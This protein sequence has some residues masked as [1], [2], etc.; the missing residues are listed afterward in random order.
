[1]KER[2]TTP[3][4]GFTLIE[5]IIVVIV[6]AVLAAISIPMYNNFQERAKH[7]AVSESV[8]TVHTAVVQNMTQNNATAED[9]GRL[10]T[11]QSNE[12]IYIYATRRNPTEGTMCIRAEWR[13][14]S[15][16]YAEEGAGCGGVNLI[17]V[18]CVQN[19]WTTTFTFQVR[20]INDTFERAQ[21]RWR[22]GN[23]NQTQTMVQGNGGSTYTSIRIID[24][25]N[26]LSVTGEAYST[27][28]S[29][30]ISNPISCR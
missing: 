19:G 10:M 24:P 11:A 2:N 30:N 25:A 22:D 3:D 7:T 12:D 23:G 15:A 6:I 13:A 1:M 17:P 16:I 20:A 4:A 27:G 14:D 8:R 28:G 26:T 21:I 9:T 18:S 5:L 29:N